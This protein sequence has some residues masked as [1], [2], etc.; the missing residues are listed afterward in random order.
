MLYKKKLGYSSYVRMA[1]FKKENR[2]G[3]LGKEKLKIKN[4]I[5]INRT[6][7]IQGFTLS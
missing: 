2:L 7:K 6:L 3:F 1:I 4:W 5:I